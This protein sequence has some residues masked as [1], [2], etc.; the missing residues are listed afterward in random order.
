M[1]L[2]RAL[3]VRAKENALGMRPPAFKVYK[4]L[5][6]GKGI[7]IPR[8]FKNTDVKQKTTLGTPTPKMNFKGKL[9]PHQTDA[10]SH[11]K[12]NGVLCLPCGKGKTA[13]ALAIA[14]RYKRRT[15]IIVHKEFLAS[16]WR[17]RIAQ[18]CPGTTVGLVQGDTCTLETDFVIAMIQTLCSREFPSDAFASIGFVIVDE[19]HHIG[20]PAFSKAMFN[21]SA[22][23]T[24]GLTAT[25]ERKDGLTKILF[26]F[27]GDIF[28]S[29]EQ[30]ACHVEHI[31]VPFNHPDFKQGPILNK[32]G[33]I[34][35]THM[36][37][38]LVDIPER[39]ELILKKLAECIK[40]KRKILVL[41]DRR[42]HCEFLHEKLG[43]DVSGLY[44]GGMTSEEHEKASHKQVILATFCLAYEGLDIPSLNT[45]FLVT[46]HSDIKQA[47]GRITR[48]ADSNKEVYDFV[49]SWSIFDSMFYK[50][51]KVFEPASIEK[52]LI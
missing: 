1:D 36:V 16:Q 30:D 10:M 13:T 45:L 21:F 6:G 51:K 2:K 49:D 23:Y 29:M 28:Y 3:T 44:I 25:P 20:A 42:H 8:F 27:L 24:L 35:M 31:K 34:S 50:R 11:F 37:N 18:F 17:E 22:E 40:R 26:W 7:Q 48:N 33:K 12:G 52:C 4:E 5:P 43:T 9:F 14:S 46:P 32:A 15:L 41:S 19:A 47:V 38:I 39:N